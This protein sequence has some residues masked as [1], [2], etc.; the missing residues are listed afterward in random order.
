MDDIYCYPNSNVLKNNLDIQDAKLLQTTEIEITSANLLDLQQHPV[1][2]NFDFKHLC[3]IHKRIFQDLYKWAGQTRTVD[4]GKGNLFCLVQNI[5]SYAD[6]IFTSYYKDCKNT[7]HDKSQFI[8]ALTNHYADT[9]ALHPFR[10]GN[11]RAQR[12]FARELCEHF[13]YTFDLSHTSHKQMLDAS[14]ESFNTGD[15][16]KLKT[17][18]CDAIRPIDQQYQQRLR[19]EIPI[20]S[21]DD[22]SDEYTCEL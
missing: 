19:R 4:I 21:S 9:N 14:I 3:E 20:L 8:D 2:G 17:I 11:G 12:E 18:F 5:P 1:H 16:S 10:E 15:N 22:I 6:S 7:K 13:G